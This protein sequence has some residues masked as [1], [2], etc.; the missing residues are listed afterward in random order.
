MDFLNNSVLPQSAEHIQLLH[1][2]LILIQFLFIPFI[3]LLF[4]GS[5]LSLLMKRRAKK[6]GEEKYFNF[7]KD[8]MEFV[9]ISKSVGVI[10]GIVPLITM[11]LIY[12]QL[13]QNSQ[14]S[15]LNFLVLSLA[16]IVI[17]L[18]LI[19]SFRYSLSFK[20]IFKAISPT[21]INDKDISS[22][23]KKISEES[24]HISNTAGKYGVIFLFLGIWLFIT[25][26][27]IP[28]YYNQWDIS[29]FIESIFALKVLTRLV[30]YILFSFTLTGGLILFRYFN[31]EK[32]SATSEND[33]YKF[34]K[35]YS[36]NVS[37]R[38]GIF[39]PLFMLFNL[40]SI[41]A[42][43]LSGTV[44]TY[45]VFSLLLL[46][47]GYHFLYMLNKSYSAIFT[48][49]L[50]LVL[51]FSLGF[52]IV[53]EQTIM[54][55]STKV[56][57]AILSADFEKYLAGLKGE[58]TGTEVNG[59]EIYKVRCESCH[60]FDQ[61]LIGPAHKDVLP[62]YVGKEAQ[63]VAFIRN[64]VKVNP[65]FPPMP[66]PGLKPNEAEAV[67]KYLLERFAEEQK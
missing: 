3:S 31:L 28:I 7:A 6:F 44:F 61:K 2:L 42:V 8:I 66:N 26:I 19:Y 53:S 36:K 17:S 57:S 63:L 9:T 64:P 39:I 54:K 67:A 43:D 10:I 12:A 38:S 23:I 55:N 11:I 48:S 21:E 41:P 47:L 20:R 18:I 40:L 50:F 13:L 1:Y 35:S 51:V 49:L 45:L 58:G 27:T 65:E 59:A 22:E 14:I 52:F 25:G 15:N 37:I 60:R 46:F 32:N 16:S 5:I 24:D 62:K 56:Q 4:G 30:L 29:S 34:V 33:Y